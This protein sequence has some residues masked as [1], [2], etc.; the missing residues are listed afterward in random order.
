MVV[1]D[2][3]IIIHRPDYG[4]FEPQIKLKVNPSETVR[5]VKVKI[6]NQEGFL[7]A[8]QSLIFNGKELEDAQTLSDYKIETN[9]RLHLMLCIHNFTISINVTAERTIT[10]DNVFYTTTIRSIKEEI[11]LQEHVPVDKQILMLADKVLQDEH[12]LYDCGIYE[13]FT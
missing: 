13:N 7:P 9:S 11:K 5:D 3:S 4:E 1:M 8:W 6:Q 10:L 2:V 12:T